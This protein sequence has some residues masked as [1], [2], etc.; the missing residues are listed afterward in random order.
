MIGDPAAPAPASRDD[1][2]TLAAALALSVLA[3]A[4][5]VFI[6]RGIGFFYDEWSFVF[7]RR[8]WSADTFLQP[9]NEHIAVLPVLIYKALFAVAGLSTHW[10]YRVLPAALHAG[11]GLTVFLL[12]RSRIGSPAAL[13]AA[14]LV[15]VMGRTAQNILWAFQIGFLGSVLAG[16]LALLALDRGRRVWACIALVTAMLCSSLGVPFALGVAAEQLARRER[17]TL[18]IPAV[19]LALYTLWYLGYARGKSDITADSAAQAAQW[20]A[21]AAA[22]SAGSVA[23]LTIDWGRTLLVLLVAVLLVR[24]VRQG[25]G[26]ARLTGLIVTVVAFW[27]LSGMARSLTVDPSASR[28]LTLGGVVI[29]LVIVELLRGTELNGRALAVGAV[30]VVF[31]GLASLPALRGYAKEQQRW[32]G[33]VA[34]ELGALQLVPGSAPAGFRPDPTFAPQLTAGQY[35][36]AVSDLGSSPAD[37]PA[38]LPRAF[39]E[40][41]Q[42]ADRILQALALQAVPAAGGRLTAGSCRP[43]G[44]T[45]VDVAV[46]PGGLRFTGRGQLAVGV[47]RFADGFVNPPSPVPVKGATVV[48]FA[49]DRSPVPYRA[50]VSR[51]GGD[52]RLC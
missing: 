48:R 23:G 33:I 52:V 29:V 37:S 18:W 2:W 11:I 41:R 38:E 40:E 47:R 13:V 7:T 8:G 50:Q 4:A 43:L 25:L 42:N 31:A 12:A 46:P 32:S 19:P 51:A 20:A 39:N 9:H 14:G 6:G 45:P 24:A 27:G 44:A 35:L 1:R 16:L 28:Y 5:L 15:L 30:L 36:D 49:R 26:S 22:A 3:F 34:A 17:R 21:N 10:P